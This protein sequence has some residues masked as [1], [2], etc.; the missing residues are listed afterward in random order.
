L[1]SEIETGWRKG[2]LNL[3]EIIEAD[4]AAGRILTHTEP[5]RAQAA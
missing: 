3:R 1:R 4:I 5:R 2:L